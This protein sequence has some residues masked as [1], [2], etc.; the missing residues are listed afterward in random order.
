[1]GFAQCYPIMKVA[2][3]SLAFLNDMMDLDCGAVAAGMSADIL[4]L[5]LD[6]ILGFFA[7]TGVECEIGYRKEGY[8]SFCNLEK[9]FLNML[10][11]D[12]AASILT[13]RYL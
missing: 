4:L 11:R 12:H 5:F 8:A 10:L 6:C 2:G 7:E 3:S 9:I 1:M 13:Q